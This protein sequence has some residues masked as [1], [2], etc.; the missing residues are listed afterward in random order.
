M[1][2]ARTFT[3]G[4]RQRRSARWLVFVQINGDL[5]PHQVRKLYRRRFGIE[6]S[7]RT[8][9]QVRLRTN[10]RNPALRFVYLALG[11]V[12][13]NIWITLRF[14]Y[15]QIPRRDGLL[16]GLAQIRN[17]LRHHRPVQPARSLEVVGQPTNYGVGPSTVVF[18]QGQPNSPMQVLPLQAQ[19]LGK[20]LDDGI[21]EARLIL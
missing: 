5:P 1:V 11:F 8:M 9:R 10:S 6:S 19:E 21:E 3:T 13:V 4:P 15:C 20:E 14:A 18:L 12:L 17:R 16:A 7:Y 2:V